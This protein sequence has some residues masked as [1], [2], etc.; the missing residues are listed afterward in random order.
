MR[1]LKKLWK[2]TYEIPPLRGLYNEKVVAES[3]KGAIEFL[4]TFYN[5]QIRIMNVNEVSED[6]NI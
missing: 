4:E 1:T 3:Q 6:E 5:H 2:I